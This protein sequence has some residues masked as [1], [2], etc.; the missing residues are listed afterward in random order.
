MSGVW[1]LRPQRVQGGALAFHSRALPP[2]E[3]HR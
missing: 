2:K 3:S 1:G